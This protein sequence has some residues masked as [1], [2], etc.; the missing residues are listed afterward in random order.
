MKTKDLT[1][2]GLIHIYCGD[3]KGKTTCGMGL[4]ARAA[5][6]GKK[7][8]IFQFMKDNSGTERRVLGSIPNIDLLDGPSRVRFSFRMTEEE[9][10]ERR[11]YYDGLLKE[12]A[13]KVRSEGYDVLFLDEALYA[14]RAGLLDEELLAGFLDEKPEHLEVILT[15]QDP[16]GRLRSAADY[17]SEIR[18]IKHPFDNGVPA[19]DGI[20]K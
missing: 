1:K 3:G 8:M 19:R 9:K 12:I 5:G 7:V 10:R 15:G 6:A 16:G 18:K 20:E 2:T 14:I 11:A 13:R 4:C 17:I